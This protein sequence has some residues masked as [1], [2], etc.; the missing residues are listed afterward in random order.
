MLQSIRPLV[1][2]GNPVAPAA[3]GKTCFDFQM[4]EVQQIGGRV[5]QGRKERVGGAEAPLAQVKEFNVSKLG[6][7]RRSL[8][9]EKKC[10]IS[11]LYVPE[12]H[13]LLEVREVHLQDL[14]P[15][16]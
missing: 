13:V 16:A 2:E 14:E 1:A 15:R 5:Y 4:S 10:W 8:A 3:L 7:P 12:C 6:W 11:R 9:W